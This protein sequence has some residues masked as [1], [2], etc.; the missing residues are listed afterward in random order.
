ML[1]VLLW[2]LIFVALVFGLLLQLWELI[3]F[4]PP[5]SK[6][7]QTEARFALVRLTAM[8]ATLGAVVAL[9]FTLV[10][11]N[12]TREANETAVQ[13]I[14]TDRINKAVEGLGATKS[15]REQ[16]Q[17]QAG[18]P[19]YEKTNIGKND[20][21][22]PVIVEVTKP[23]LEVRIGAIYSLERISQDSPRD[24]IQIMEILCAYIKENSQAG[25]ATRFPE[26]SDYNF[27]SQE[28]TECPPIRT[29]IQVALDVIGRRSVELWKLEREAGYRLD[30]PNC[31]FQNARF[32][33][34][35]RSANFNR[36]IFEQADLRGGDFSDASFRHCQMS[37]CTFAGV[38]FERVD[39]FAAVFKH[40][41]FHPNGRRPLEAL[42]ASSGLGVQLEK[43]WVEETKFDPAK[44][45]VTA[46]NTTFVFC[47]FSDHF[48]LQGLFGSQRFGG[49]ENKFIDC[50]FRGINLEGISGRFN[51]DEFFG[52]ASVQTVALPPHW[53]NE[54]LSETDFESKWREWRNS[55][56]NA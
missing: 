2:L 51:P 50:A 21:S 9:P 23:N 42:M 56:Y 4:L 55:S 52:D 5:E 38:N 19:T 27:R 13:G 39:L 12:L 7:E 3:W 46:S 18:N 24:H 14:V 26:V 43:C 33:K 29:D 41:K 25:Q 49:P 35:W 31:N 28:W 53:P 11:V 36:S 37:K 34:N 48:L 44:S 6:V 16:R 45:A 20:Y 40:T 15:V 54:V 10:K 32:R 8:T 47:K 30:L 17:D 22:K 1:A